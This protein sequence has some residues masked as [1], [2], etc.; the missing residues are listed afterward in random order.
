[1]SRTPATHWARRLFVRRADLYLP[2]FHAMKERGVREAAAVARV[3]RRYDVA[4]GAHILDLCCGIGRHSVPLA[5]RGYRVTGIDLS[6]AFLS[7]ARRYAA[8][9]RVSDRAQFLQGDFLDLPPTLDRCGPFD[10]VVSGWT[11]LGYYGKAADQRAFAAVAR[12]TRTGGVLVLWAANKDWILRYFQPQG[13]GKAGNVIVL[14]DRTF[15][16]RRSFMVNRWEFLRREGRLLQSQGAFTIAHRIYSPPELR[17][18]L[19]SVGWRVRSI[20]A[21]FRG[22]PLD[23][24]IHDRGGMVVV[25]QRK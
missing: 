24:R 4:R 7:A 21:N 16:R 13:W 20:T 15:D 18:L 5:S 25:A 3:F 2:F 1:M 22:D 8:R 12:R 6:P 11:S 23:I 17:A 10:G 14:E 9:R 19:E